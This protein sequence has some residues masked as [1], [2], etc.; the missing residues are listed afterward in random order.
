MLI[1]LILGVGASFAADN[2][3]TDEIQTI[4]EETDTTVSTSDAETVSVS[5]NDTLIS[6]SD[7]SGKTLGATG[8]RDELQTLINNNYGKEISLEKDYLFTSGT[9]HAGIT[10]TDSITI[11]GKGHIINAAK[12]GRIFQITGTHV[13]LKNLTLNGQSNAHGG[14][15]Y[16]N[17][18]YGTI[19]HCNVYNG[20]L[21]GG[22]SNCGVGIYVNQRYCTVSY[23]NFIDNKLQNTGNPEE[24]AIRCPVGYINVS[25]SL[26]KRNTATSGDGDVPG[27][28]ID[29]GYSNITYCKFEDNVAIDCNSALYIK[30]Y[31]YNVFRGLKFSVF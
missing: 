8:D 12:T 19:D 23:C 27:A 25:H 18:Q 29:V 14:I 15:I 31:Y 26:F 17:G 11:N 24:S 7:D 9:N 30:G 22:N 5:N 6:V 13:V 10:I 1:V 20:T 21:T 3:Q 4:N 28:W 2:N 16:W